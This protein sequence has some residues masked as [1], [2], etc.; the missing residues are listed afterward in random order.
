MDEDDLPLTKYLL[1]FNEEEHWDSEEEFSVEGESVEDDSCGLGWAMEPIDFDTE[2]FVDDVEFT[3]DKTDISNTEEEVKEVAPIE[4][5][6]SSVGKVTKMA[7]SEEELVHDDGKKQ[8]LKKK[9]TKVK[10]HAA[11]DSVPSGEQSAITKPESKAAVKNVTIS[12]NEFQKPTNTAKSHHRAKVDSVHSG[13]TP[14]ITKPES[15]VT[16]K[17]VT[18]S[19]KELQKPTNTAKSHHHAKVDSV[20]SGEKP[21]KTTPDSKVAVKNV[22][23]ST[24]KLQKP[25]NTAKSHH[26]A[27]VDSVHSGEK[28]AK[29]TPDSKVAVK[30]VTISTKKL[31]KPTNTAKS[32]AE[33]AKDQR[34]RKKKYVQELQGTIEELQ[35]DKA[36]LQQVT[37]QLSD[38]IEGLRDEIRYLKGVIT[39]QSE[40]ARIL[41]GVANTP[42][43]SLSCNVLQNNEGNDGKTNKRKYDDPATDS[44]KK[45]VNVRQENSKKRK[46]DKNANSEV[47]T[48]DA[49]VCVHVQSGKVSLEFCAECS[50]KANSIIN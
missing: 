35:R 48:I 24:K 13:E 28:P 38:T 42:G 34:E 9:N 21:A 37:T 29:T 45:G 31:Q 16:V 30:N 44:G 1:Q 3:Q 17:T 11:V 26:H 14:A 22:T 15:K 18:I 25:T 23:I 40:L 8:E 50:K 46:L 10:S 27:K 12:T 4:E 49:G 7:I 36:G 39:N 20:P 43:I 47:D 2:I 6:S 32:Q 5:K 33:K 19:T 41:R